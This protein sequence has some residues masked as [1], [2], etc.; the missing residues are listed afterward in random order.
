MKDFNFSI[1]NLKMYYHLTHKLILLKECLEINRS[2]IF[3][4]CFKS[5]F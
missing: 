5:K 3:N 1:L 4:N 2:N